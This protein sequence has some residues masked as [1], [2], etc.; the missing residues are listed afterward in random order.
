M[1]ESWPRGRYIL[2]R[3]K[4]SI[5]MFKVQQLMIQTFAVIKIFAVVKILSA[6][7]IFVMKAR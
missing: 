4:L 3:Q 5:A 2:H 1:P 7:L 6:F